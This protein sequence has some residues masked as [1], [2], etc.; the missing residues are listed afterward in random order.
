MAAS[1]IGGS[2]TGRRCR[3]AALYKTFFGLT[4]MDLERRC[5]E[6]P[7]GNGKL[8]KDPE[9]ANPISAESVRKS[10]TGWCGTMLA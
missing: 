6:Q 1:R 9:H 5:S 3:Q 2:G 10:L 7:C 8:R 4:G